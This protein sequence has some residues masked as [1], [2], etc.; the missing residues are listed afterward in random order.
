M[1]SSTN[2][3]M[4]CEGVPIGIISY[5]CGNVLSIRN[6]LAAVG[7]SEVRIIE[8]PQ[9]LDRV[10]KII[11]PG[12]GAFD[13]ACLAL[14]AAGLFQALQEFLLNDGNKALGVCLG[15]QILCASSEEGKEAGLGVVK[16]SVKVLNASKQHKTPHVGWNTV[17]LKSDDP[18]LEGLGSEQ[19]FYFLH[20]YHVVLNRET[21]CL[22]ITE[23]GHSITAI[24]RS[25]NIWG[26]QFHPEKSQSSGL[27][28][29]SNFV[30]H[31]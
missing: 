25:R 11:L 19:D 27:R 26:V 31:A 4:N 7:V 15:M 20:S 18:I 8:S 21:K 6:A 30:R 24:L 10:T 12:V 14:K 23:H 3:N 5:Q 2:K 17:K 13:S 22:G 1:G 28:L 16:G 29:L 9:D